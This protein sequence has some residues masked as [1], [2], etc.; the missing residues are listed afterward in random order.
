MSLRYCWE[1]QQRTYKDSQYQMSS[2]IRVTYNSGSADDIF[3]TATA[4]EIDPSGKFRI[5]KDN[6]SSTI[7][8]ENGTNDHYGSVEY[9]VV[10]TDNGYTNY[11]DSGQTVKEDV[12]VSTVYEKTNDDWRSYGGSI[13]C[14]RNNKWE[15]DYPIQHTLATSSTTVIGNVFGNAG[16]YPNNGAS[17][18]YYYVLKGSDTID[19]TAINVPAGNL[20]VGTPITVSINP[21]TGIVYGGNVS[22]RYQVQVNGGEWTDIV[23]STP[24]TSI[25]YNIQSGTTS[26]AFRVQ[27]SDDLGFTSTD[28]IQSSTHNVE[29]L[30]GSRYVWGQY[31][32]K[33]EQLWS[34]EKDEY[35]SFQFKT[36][37]GKNK[38]FAAK[39]L[40]KNQYSVNVSSNE[41]HDTDGIAAGGSVGQD[42]YPMIVFADDESDARYGAL[43]Y[44]IDTVEDSVANTT[45]SWRVSSTGNSI[46]LSKLSSGVDA[47]PFTVSHA[48]QTEQSQTK[49]DLI[50]NKSSASSDAFPMD[51]ISG[52]YWYTYEGR[53]NIDPISISAQSGGRIGGIVSATLVPSTNKVY[54]GN[55]SYHY[56]VRRNGGAEWEDVNL[57][58]PNTTVTYTI[59]LGTTQLQFR[60]SAMDDIGFTS[61]V[62][63]ESNVV[64]VIQFTESAQIL[65]RKNAADGYDVIWLE[66]DSDVVIRP[67]GTK[68][69]DVLA[70]I[71]SRL[72]GL[73]V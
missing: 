12:L 23:A 54:G 70:N 29:T 6:I 2:G 62:W 4:Y 44:W 35:S 64:D 39:G 17:G 28:W 59:P 8:M 3:C 56:Q 11:T 33:N 36:I 60:V 53:D 20:V 5:R 63:V 55:V 26:L 25:I 31:T 27:A 16:D 52:S 30:P 7:K 22:Y 61:D 48:V 66:T 51:G 46:S 43:R 18:S 41:L 65:H 69:S 42:Y 10:L 47:I 57:N 15:M 68:L 49:G 21:S 72:S 40:N 37:T 14:V 34:I 9:L 73:G 32:I 38:A 45:S 1:K 50:G 58:T 67:D 71:E 13:V 19:P 24:D